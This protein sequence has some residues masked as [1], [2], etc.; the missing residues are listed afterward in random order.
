MPHVFTAWGHDGDN[1][2]WRGHRE[3]GFGVGG[4]GRILQLGLGDIQPRTAAPVYT[5]GYGANSPS[6]PK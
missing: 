1:V 6:L 4:A 5:L 3:R 2:H